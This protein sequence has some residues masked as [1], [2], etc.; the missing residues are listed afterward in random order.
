MIAL[1]QV[2]ILHAYIPSSHTRKCFKVL[3]KSDLRRRSSPVPFDQSA[4]A[5]PVTGQLRPTHSCLLSSCL[6]PH[7][8]LH[9]GFFQPATPLAV[10]LCLDVLTTSIRA[11]QGPRSSEDK[12][13]HALLP[14]DMATVPPT[15]PTRVARSWGSCSATPTAIASVPINTYSSYNPNSLWCSTRH[16]NILAPR[17]SS[18][19]HIRSSLDDHMSQSRSFVEHFPRRSQLRKRVMFDSE[20]IFVASP[21][22]S[23]RK[24]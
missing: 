9:C 17:L 18:R 1:H 21:D 5:V 6:I 22:T 24:I 3:R 14:H 8:H 4:S 2:L 13:T 11:Q 19:S 16:S 20:L 12:V 7:T 10:I 23:G 15:P